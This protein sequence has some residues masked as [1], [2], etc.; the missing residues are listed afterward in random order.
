MKMNHDEQE[1]A[2][3]QH[4]M[5]RRCEC[6]ARADSKELLVSTFSVKIQTSSRGDVTSIGFAFSM[7]S[8]IEMLQPVFVGFASRSKH[9]HYWGHNR[10]LIMSIATSH[11]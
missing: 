9:Y 1:A 2:S 7:G 10:L 5:P 8:P 6:S 3:A 11:S 4:A